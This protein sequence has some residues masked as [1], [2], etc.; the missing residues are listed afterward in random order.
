MDERPVSEFIEETPGIE[1]HQEIE[2]LKISLE[3]QKG[4]FEELQSK[5]QEFRNFDANDWGKTNQAELIKQEYFRP[6]HNYVASIYTV[7][8]HSQRIVD[9]FG[10]DDLYSEYTNEIV[11]MELDELGEFLRQLRHYT[12][13]R[14]V[15]P[16]ET[17]TTVSETGL[18]FRLYIS[19][20]QMLDWDEWNS[21]AKSYLESIPSRILLL[22]VIEEYQNRSEEFYDWFFRYIR[23]YFKDELEET[24]ER[25]FFVETMKSSMPEPKIEKQR[26]PFL[27]GYREKEVMQMPAIPMEYMH[28]Y[29]PENILNGL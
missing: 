12:Q 22:D 15:P 4:N 23:F 28:P 3:I 9:N 6:F 16:V 20:E 18:E 13:K 7:I 25:I 14:K 5:H 8:K 21:D 11:E 24:L 17:E 27:H 1:I 10:G 2:S 19:K 26:E 29:D